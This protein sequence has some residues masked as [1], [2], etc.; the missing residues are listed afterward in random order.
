M[1]L[2]RLLQINMATLAGLATLLLSMGQDSPAQP[3][4]VWLAAGASIWLT[5]VKGWVRLNRTV[6]GVCALA[7]G[8][9][10]IA[11]VFRVER[12]A[13]LLDLA[14]LVVC[15][16]VVLFFQKKDPLIYWLLAIISLSQVIVAALFSHGGM[17][18]L[19]LV[20]YMMTG[21]SALALL[22]LYSQGI[23]YRRERELPRP[24]RAGG[25]RG[26]HSAAEAAFTGS[27][28]GGGRA[29]I[30]AELFQRLAMLG[31][32]T[33]VLATVIFF[34]VPRRGYPAWRGAMFAQPIVGFTD[35]V[36][37][38]QL[39]EVLESREEVMRVELTE[40]PSGRM[41]PIQHQLYL[42][43]AVLT[44]YNHGQWS[45]RV[46]RRPPSEF[47]PPG[48]EDLDDPPDNE[49]QDGLAAAPAAARA[50]LR[51]VRQR[52]TVEPLDRDELFCIWPSINL[53]PADGRHSPP[54]FYDPAQGRSGCARAR[55]AD[56]G[57]RINWAPRP[58]RTAS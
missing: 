24:L 14:D 56:S 26:P 42:H 36:A 58:W 21:V 22:F 47:S 50:P 20:L 33:L 2:Q 10:F 13:W 40:V 45:N 55:S 35:T 11:H 18:G 43:G 41:Y 30:V 4:L 25:S 48:L 3:L 52:I 57:S 28:V 15:L 53:S 1:Y 16:Q 29:G 9:Y 19:V 37:L 32:G 51:W 31:L 23:R 46:A 54:V 44:N 17:F 49:E 27:S 8:V 38:G 5:N 34:T 39:G 7:I 12:E 6:A